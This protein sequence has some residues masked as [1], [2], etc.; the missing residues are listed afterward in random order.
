MTNDDKKG[1]VAFLIAAIVVAGCV[2]AL[3]GCDTAEADTIKNANGMP[4][5]AISYDPPAWMDLC[6]RAYKVY[7]RTTGDAWW[8]L[9][10]NGG[11][12]YVVLPL[13]EAEDAVGTQTERT[14]E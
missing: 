14:P 6:T 4:L 9:V 8:L 13:D 1:W 2:L 5:D 12:K 3:C 11:S 7:D 10:M